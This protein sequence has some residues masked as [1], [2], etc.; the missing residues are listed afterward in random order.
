MKNLKHLL[1]AMSIA[2]AFFSCEKAIQTEEVSVEA[3]RSEDL[4]LTTVEEEALLQLG[5]G[6][7][8]RHRIKKFK[9][10][11][12]TEQDLTDPR[13]GFGSG[14]CLDTAFPFFNVQKGEEGRA[15]YLGNFTSEVTFCVKPPGAGESEIDYKDGKGTFFLADGHE[16]YI[17]IPVGVVKLIPQPAQYQAKFQDRF[18]IIGG[19]GPYENARGIGIT[20]SFVNFFPEGGDRTQHT[21]YGLILLD[22]G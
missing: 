22:E 5:G 7:Y 19:T 8:G 11:F 13:L 9:A 12:V 20:N 16:L 4:T 2:F 1:F 6:F 18:R 17:E 14:D 15:R 3:E 21:W 10:K